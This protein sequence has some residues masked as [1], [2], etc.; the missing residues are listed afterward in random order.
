MKPLFLSFLIAFTA[1]PTIGLSASQ[2]CTSDADCPAGDFC[3]EGECRIAV[4]D[5]RDANAET[6]CSL[7]DSIR[8]Y[9][10]EILSECPH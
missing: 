3:I 5:P 10:N 1:V 9:Q 8:S 6:Q 2:L 7:S 4:A